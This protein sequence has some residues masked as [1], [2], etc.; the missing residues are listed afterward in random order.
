MHSRLLP[1]APDG[2][3]LSGVHRQALETSVVDDVDLD[4][5]QGVLELKKPSTA[6]QNRVLVESL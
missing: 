3:S 1:L 5:P 6:G 2:I 4:H